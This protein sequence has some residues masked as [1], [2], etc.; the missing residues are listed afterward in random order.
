[1]TLHLMGGGRN[2]ISG[3]EGSQA[4]PAC[5]SGRGNAYDCNYF[6]CDAGRAACE[7]CSATW[8]FGTNSVFAL[9]PRKPTESLDRFG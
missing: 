9:G 2:Y 1:V 6:L 7:A 4:V 5:P 8:D 3:F